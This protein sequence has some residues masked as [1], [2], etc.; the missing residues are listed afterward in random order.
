MFAIAKTNIYLEDG[1]DTS[2]HGLPSQGRSILNCARKYND[3][4]T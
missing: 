3:F 1:S 4:I 2:D